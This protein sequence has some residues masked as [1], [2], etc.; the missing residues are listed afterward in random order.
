MST[1]D[2]TGRNDMTNETLKNVLDD[3]VPGGRTERDDDA[4]VV[5]D[6][7]LDQVSGGLTDSTGCGGMT[8]SV[9]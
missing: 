6:G 1:I 9:F 3:G 5:D 4:H 7:D 8:C 2:Y